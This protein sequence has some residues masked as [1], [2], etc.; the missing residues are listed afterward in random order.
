MQTSKTKKSIVI[1]IEMMNGEFKIMFK[2]Y[3]LAYYLEIIKLKIK[4][5]QLWPEI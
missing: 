4:N 2:N 1:E 3:K 5:F